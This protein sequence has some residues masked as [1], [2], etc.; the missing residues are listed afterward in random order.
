[1]IRELSSGPRPRRY[2]D[3]LL[4]VSVLT[5]LGFSAGAN[6]FEIDTGNSDVQLRWDNTV[7]YTIGVRANDC[8]TDICGDGQG[9]GD[10]SA[11]QSDSRFGKAGDIITNRLDLLSE[12]DL[13][14]KGRTGFRLSGAGWYDDAYSG[15]KPKGDPAL[16]AAGVNAFPGGEYTNYI[17][18][19]NRG[20]SAEL[21]DAFVFTGFDVGSTSVNMKLGQH[22]IYWGESL[23]SFVNG[24]SYSQGPV[25]I[26]KAMANPGSE[27]K[28]LFKPLNQFSFSASPNDRLTIS[29][30]YMFDWKPSV[31]PDGGTYFGPADFFTAGGGTVVPFL[32]VP[33]YF[34]GTKAPDKK[35]GDFGLAVHWR[36]EWL[37]GTLG[38]YYREYTDK[39]PQMVI[40]GMDASGALHVD[41]DYQTP[42]Q[43]M[44]ALS[45]SK[46]IGD[47]SF[48]ADL[49]YRKNAQLAAT[50]FSNVIAANASG[51]DW[52]PTGD[53]WTALVNATAYFGKNAIFDSAILMGEVNYSMLDK[54]NH[55]P[56]NVYYGKTANCGSDGV[57]TNHGCP[58]RDAWGL[59][60]LF[61]PK[62][63][64]VVD[65]T[66]LSMPMFLGLGLKGNSPVPFGDNEGQGNW[67]IG[68]TADIQS[69]YLVSLKYNGFLAKHS[70]DAAGIASNS[71]SSLGKYW[72]RDWLSLTFKTTF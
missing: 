71:N 22:N 65:G 60:V 40:G 50:P 8:D 36:P 42:R 12:L 29:G 10:V 3:G 4:Y 61:E 18:R 7:R 27:A 26:R 9:G 23:F 72:D 11:H 55:D 41:L 66:D 51:I 64:Q 63:F 24:V 6:A 38:A 70:N 2:T 31:L 19:W 1:M 32:G 57:A 13:I 5:I 49:T 16:M 46:L 43:K 21:L 20:P 48:G 15:T 39:F 33:A 62:W 30:Q 54:I 34:D 25:D 35:R 44:Y 69:K 28:E 17:R 58:T 47:I 56:L 67:S 68:L 52:R 45:L 53:V 59:A 14:Y 37:G